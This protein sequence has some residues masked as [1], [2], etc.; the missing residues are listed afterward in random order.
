MVE[1]S[2]ITVCDPQKCT[3]CMLCET[4]CGRGAVRV[5]DE[6]RRFVPVI[7]ESK[8]V[9]C[10]KC[11]RYCQIEKP[12][13]AVRAEVWKQGWS[14]NE[15]IRT[16]S[17]SGGIASALAREFVRRGAYV[18]GCVYRNGRFELRLFS[19]ENEL[20]EMTGSKYV[21]SIPGTV[22]E[23]AA[24]LLETGKSVLFIGLP[25]QAAAMKRRAGAQLSKRL[26]TVDLI[27]HGAPSPKLFRKYLKDEK[28]DENRV[29]EISFR[30]KMR[31]GIR[32]RFDLN[33][34]TFDT[35]DTFDTYSR[36]FLNALDYP[37]GCYQCPYAKTERVGDL[38]IGDAW[39]TALPREEQNR[40]ISLVLIQTQKGQEMLEQCDLHL[41]DAEI[42][43]M[44]EVNG[45][46]RR[47][48]ACP[49]E[50]D[51]FFALEKEKGFSRAV[52]ACYRRNYVEWKVKEA[53][54]KTLIYKKLR[55]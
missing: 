33:G 48:S 47:P 20:G 45:Q 29:S 44:L 42:E 39:G 23:D 26:W 6:L 37:D 4:I 31:Y 13:P 3:G 10:G 38:T 21:K 54:R 36:A 40:G 16:K 12:L 50:R 1:N 52:K 49:P 30:E 8:C 32:I 11:S 55:G 46:L 41:E 19:D 2:G 25:C 18:A 9:H 7:D 51:R 22:Y 14:Q 35:F 34:G 24:R 53:I 15:V 27:C 5:V 28:L 43:K 17:S